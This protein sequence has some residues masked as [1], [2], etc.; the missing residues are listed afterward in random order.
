MSSDF[1]QLL[2]CRTGLARAVLGIV[3][4]QCV[5]LPRMGAS[6]SFDF[7]EEKLLPEWLGNLD[8]NQDCPSQSR[9]FYR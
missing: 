7:D 8:S 3:S 9:E 2:P 5:W 6:A 4:Y 1:D